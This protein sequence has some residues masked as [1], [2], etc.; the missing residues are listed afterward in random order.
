VNFGFL[1]CYKLFG[2]S[3]YGYHLLNIF[4]NCIVVWLVFR[5]GSE[6]FLSE[7]LGLLAAL[8]FALHP[9]HTEPVAWIDGISDQKSPFSTS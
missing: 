3:P 1:V 9:I 7:W 2:T 5:A 6:L 8:A 4:L